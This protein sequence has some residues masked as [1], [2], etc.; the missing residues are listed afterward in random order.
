MKKAP[1]SP[2]LITG[3]PGVG[4]TTLLKRL[5]QDLQSLH[6]VGFYTEEIRKEGKRV[7]F[8]LQS[9]QGKKGVLAHI[10]Y[11]D[12]PKVGRYGVDLPFFEAF[13]DHIPWSSPESQVIIIDEIGKMEVL[14]K[15]FQKLLWELLKNPKLFMASIAQKGNSWIE[16]FKKKASG[17]VLWLTE[18]NREAL[19]QTLKKKILGGKP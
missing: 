11:A 15:K 7:G 8:Y 16:A 13:L 1:F 12:Y 10:H 18:K 19:Y 14:S 2:I 3:H 5:S 9:F 17:E 6:P 4:K